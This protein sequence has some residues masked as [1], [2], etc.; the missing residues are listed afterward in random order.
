M[1][2]YVA[3]EMDRNKGIPEA[4][5]KASHTKLYADAAREVAAEADVAVL[6]LWKLLMNHAGWQEGET[7]LP[8]S[9]EIPPN[10]FLRMLLHD[11]TTLCYPQLPTLFSTV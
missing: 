8:G 7:P 10:M 2:E 6:D 3:E 1:N 9:K 4:R 5:R 11:G